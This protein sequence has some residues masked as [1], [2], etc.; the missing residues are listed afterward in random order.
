MVSDWSPPWTPT[1][2]PSVRDSAEVTTPPPALV[3]RREEEEEEEQ[4]WVDEAQWGC[5][6]LLADEEGVAGLKGLSELKLSA[7]KLSQVMLMAQR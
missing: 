6:L 2:F 4:C 5:R 7:A 3:F 1:V